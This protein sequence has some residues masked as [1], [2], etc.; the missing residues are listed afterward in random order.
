M[1][2]LSDIYISGYIRLKC[3]GPSE[4]IRL[5]IKSNQNKSN[6]Y[7]MKISLVKMK[8]DNTNFR[9]NYINQLNHKTNHF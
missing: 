5:N 6:I 3:K 9:K 8:S 1:Y 2:Q 7:Y 4:L